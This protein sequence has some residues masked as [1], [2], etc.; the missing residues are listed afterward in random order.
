MKMIAD[1]LESRLM[2]FDA[3]IDNDGLAIFV[4]PE[5]M[6]FNEYR[7]HGIALAA[8]NDVLQRNFRGIFRFDHVEYFIFDI[9]KIHWLGAMCLYLLLDTLQIAR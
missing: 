9:V 2:L 6:E 4:R 8:I 1:N 3:R 7:Y 5:L